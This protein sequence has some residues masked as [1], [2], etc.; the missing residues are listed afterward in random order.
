MES[1]AASGNSANGFQLI[2]QTGSKGVKV[3]EVME[4]KD[5]SLISN[6]KRRSERWA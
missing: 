4:E 5:G 3:S 6:H 2:R 1:A